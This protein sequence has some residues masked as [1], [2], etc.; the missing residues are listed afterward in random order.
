MGHG[1]R[2]IRSILLHDD[3]Y[4]GRLQGREHGWAASVLS[5]QALLGRRNPRNHNR[6]TLDVRDL[7][8]LRLYGAACS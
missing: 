3:G 1:V 8:Q 6:N 5:L 2:H 4:N 7:A